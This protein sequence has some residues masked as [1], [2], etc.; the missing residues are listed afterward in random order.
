MYVYSYIY[1][2]TYIHTHTYIYIYILLHIKTLFG[3]FEARYLSHYS[4]KTHANH[5]TLFTVPV[6]VFFRHLAYVA[7]VTIV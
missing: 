1:I 2:Y 4:M 7:I 3:W 5:Q 6:S